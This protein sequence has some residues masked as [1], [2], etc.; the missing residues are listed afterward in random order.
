MKQRPRI[1]YTESQKAL[2]WERWQKGESLQQIA[3][4]FDRNHSSIQSI[5]AATGGIAPAPRCRSRLALTL[6]EREEISRALVAGHSMRSIAAQLGRAPST[7]CREIKRNAG[8]E[9][10]RASQADQ[11]AWDRGRRPKT[12]KL[13]HNRALARI[14]AGKLQ[15]QWS[16]EQVAGWLKRIYPDDPSRQVSHE[17]IYRSLFIQARGALKK[18]LVEHLRRTRVMRRSRHHT[19][20]TDNH[21]RISD[22]VSISER[23][24]SVADR[25]LPGHWEGDLLFGSKNSQIATLVERNTRYAMLVKVSG[26]DT[27]TVINALIKNA[28]KLPDELY[29]SLTW[30]RGKEMAD[31][32]RF[33]LATHIQF[34]FCDPHHPW[35]V[36]LMRTPTDC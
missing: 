19:M 30:D 18:E 9:C 3:Q 27:Q 25:A 6:S 34:Y 23:P 22:T 21:G 2:M 31:H 29:K 10:Y 28:R 1:Y 7:I 16:P 12:S 15:L 8:Q 11:C 5:L 35:R 26:K 4:L 20:K 13:A 33:T 17:T 14:V 36:G 24:A 32:K